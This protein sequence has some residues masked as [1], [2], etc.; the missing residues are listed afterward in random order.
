MYTDHS[1][2]GA[3]IAIPPT[4]DLAVVFPFDKST[5]KFDRSF[6]SPALTDGR[7][8]SEQVESFLREAERIIKKK[9][10]PIKIVL[11]LFTCFVV[12]GLLGLFCMITDDTFIDESDIDDIFLYMMGYFGAVIFYAVLMHFYIRRK[13]RKAKKCVKSHI[14][15][16]AQAFAA[17]GVRWNTP[18]Y[19]P[20]W[21][22]LWKDYK[23]QGQ[24]AYGQQP[25]VQAF[26][27][28]YPVLPQQIPQIAQ[29]P[30]ALQYTQNLQ[31]NVN[32]QTHQA[33]KYQSNNMSGNG[34]AQPL[35]AHQQQIEMGSYQ[36][37]N[38][39]SYSNL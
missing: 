1:Q 38:L 21:I 10:N 16:H 5:K 20:Q 13:Q 23:G 2:Q 24:V 34:M 11:A 36:A 7:V 12:F 18:L 33:P 26:N 4:T 6:Y 15:K 39:N 37:P 35:L 29:Y 14:R 31:N 9:Y 3:F 32:G 27:N 19:F 25:A 22:E 8:S 17:Q 30:Q 28:V